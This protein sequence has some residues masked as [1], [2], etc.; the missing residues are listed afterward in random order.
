MSALVITPPHGLPGELM[1]MSLVLGVTRPLNSFT[2]KLNSR[3]S[4]SGSGTGAPSMKLIM[5]S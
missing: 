4:R 1:M 3:S 2:S 5:L